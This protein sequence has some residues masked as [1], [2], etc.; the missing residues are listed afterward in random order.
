M[1]QNQTV[2][3]IE[4]VGNMFCILAKDASGR[5]Y[6]NTNTV[7]ICQWEWGE[8]YKNQVCDGGETEL[9][10]QTWIPREAAYAYKKR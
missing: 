10:E 9:T 2:H 1:E 4:R 5:L 6:V 8:L 7:N 3:N